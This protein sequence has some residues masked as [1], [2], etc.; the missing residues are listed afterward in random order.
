VDDQETVVVRPATRADAGA[1]RE[2]A[3][4]AYG[5]YV[6]RI[7]REPVPMTADYDRIAESGRAWLA[8]HGN[9][10]VGLLVVEPARDHLLVENVAVAPGSQGLRVGSRL[11]RL[12]EEQARALGVREVRLYTHEKMTENLAY[13]PGAATARRTAAPSTASAGSSSPSS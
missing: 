10:V 9:R 3:A 8:E 7:G 2:L 4:A 5:K 1:M 13:Y 12:A 11:L 6:D